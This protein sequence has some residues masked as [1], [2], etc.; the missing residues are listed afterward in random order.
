[1][2]MGQVFT[3]TAALLSFLLMPYTALANNQSY[4]A[5]GSSISTGDG[6]TTAPILVSP[7]G[8]FSCGFY[9]V[10][11]NAF[12]FSI[13]FSQSADRTVAW[14]ANRD[15]PVNGNGSRIVFQRSGSL[16]LLDYDGTAV[17]STNTAAIHADSAALL[18]TGSLV[19]M[20]QG[21]NHL[22]SSFN[23]PTDTLLPSQ[24]M[25][26]NT[27]LVSAS[28][29]GLLSSGFYTF[30]F[31]SNYT[32]SLIYNRT[33]EIS[34]TYWPT[35]NRPWANNGNRNQ[36]C[37]L[38]SKGAF[39]A[40]D[41]LKFEASDL[42]DGI[43]R[44]LTLDYDGNLR[45]YSLNMTTHSWSI[46]GMLL[47]QLC[48][49]HGLCGVNSLCRYRPEP[50]CSCI[51]GFEV[52]EPSDWSKGCERKTNSVASNEVT[53]TK[54]PGTDFLGYELKYNMTMTWQNCMEMCLDDGDCQAFGFRGGTDQCYLKTL[55]FSGFP[56]PYTDFY[57]KVPVAA[58]QFQKFPS[59]S[60]Q[61][62]VC[63]FT[64]TMA[65]PIQI[66]PQKKFKFGYF[67]TSALTLLVVEVTLI[68][69]GFWVLHKWKRRPDPTDVGS[70]IIYGQFCRFSYRELQKATNCFHEE[71]GRGGSGVVYKGVLSD[72]RKVA[73]KKLSD[74]I[75]GEQEFRSELSVIGRIYHMNVVRIWGFCAEKTHRLLVSEFVEKG[76]LD[77]VLFDNL[78]LSPVLQWSQRYNI[79]L[80][81][82]KGLAYLHHE[83]LEWIVHCDVKPENILLDEEFEPK[84]A[85]FGL[86]KL[87]GRGV[88]AQMLSRVHGTRG[89]I[90]PE[91][92]LNL[93][94]T[95]KADVYSY[96][97][98]LLE[99]VMGTRVSSQV[100]QGE[101]EVEVEMAVGHYAKN[102]K[103]KFASKNQSWLLEFV[104][105]RLRGEFDNLQAGMMLKIAVS[106]VEE[107]RRR[108]PNMSY[109]VESLVSL[110]E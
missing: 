11:T 99:L 13:W 16:D 86:V 79:A 1:M 75:Q 9:K 74:M 69:I 95:G 46:S 20:D 43:M 97:V 28:A 30:Y 68:L 22:W 81:V 18:D 4:L 33:N 5:R 12:T 65:P 85:D 61:S 71:L 91:W 35:H 19:I 53:F 21:G 17:W 83:C 55:L 15:T 104:D 10:A 38:D 109:V 47:A 78:N 101:G 94:I 72:E 90:A 93:P 88:G 25:A 82:A 24:S 80:G 39:V 50:E 77:R 84:I 41:Q 48:E 49:I 8:V 60:T 23:S 37:G 64:E 27:R 70:M 108:R 31:D 96:G 6:T 56:E 59:S 102:L 110:V 73:V 76:S 42:G 14:T 107:E 87:L 100:V 2:A 45:M 3:F 105:C 40:G 103:E 26:A 57:L 36:Y 58:L 44:R 92:A 67:L 32:S 98:V 29:N 63:K 54:L 34:S 51:E 62:L 7:N 106:C 52:I 66:S 89:Y